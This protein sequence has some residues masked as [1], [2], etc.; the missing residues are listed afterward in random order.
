VILRAGQVWQYCYVDGSTRVCLVLRSGRSPENIPYHTL[1]NLDWPLNPA[2]VGS[3][4]I[5]FEDRLTR[6]WE[7]V[8]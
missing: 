6:H 5:T 7:R 2:K 8:A 1:L 4:D 3:Q